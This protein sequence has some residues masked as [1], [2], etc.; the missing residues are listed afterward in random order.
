MD[1]TM[2]K[3]TFRERKK[4][5]ELCGWLNS[6]GRGAPDAGVHLILKEMA[7][8]RAGRLVIILVAKSFF[9]PSP[10]PSPPV[11]GRGDKRKEF[12]A[13]AIGRAVVGRV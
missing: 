9:S 11:G 4:Q 2:A 6:G 10:Y 1:F 8:S 7:G 13:N 3:F 5:G 12:L